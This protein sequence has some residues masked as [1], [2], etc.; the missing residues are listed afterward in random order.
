MDH[1]QLL[2]MIK[3]ALNASAQPALELGCNSTPANLA[4]TLRFVEQQLQPLKTRIAPPALPLPS[5]ECVA[6]FTEGRTTP[7]ETQHVVA[8]AIH[9][10]GILFQLISAVETQLPATVSEPLERSLH[11]RL[12]ALGPRRSVS[13][14]TVEPPAAIIRATAKQA[15]NHSPLQL[16][17][18]QPVTVAQPANRSSRKVWIVVLV[19]AASL[20]LLAGT[21]GVLGLLVWSSR[22]TDDGL[23]ASMPSNLTGTSKT[24]G[25]SNPSVP[26]ASHVPGSP[27]QPTLRDAP[28]L[29]TV[30]SPAEGTS[31][32]LPTAN[33]D[34][35][36]PLDKESTQDNVA[37]R[38]S[39]TNIDR[40][41]VA[42]AE[43]RAS[44]A[45][46]PPNAASP[47]PVVP[48][49]PL[50]PLVVWREVTGILASE[51]DEGYDNWQTVSVDY[52]GESPTEHV[53]SATDTL[54]ELTGGSALS[55]EGKRRITWLTLPT[56]YAKGDLAGGGQLVMGQDTSLKSNWQTAHSAALQVVFGSI[57][58]LDVPT[59]MELQ[60]A[61]DDQSS[62]AVAIEA[63]SSLRVQ[64]LGTAL[65]LALFSGRAR[66]GN[67][68]IQAG[69]K[70]LISDSLAAPV[71]T[72]PQ[73][74]DLTTIPEWAVRLP[75]KSAVP[76]NILANLDTT[77]ALSVALDK[78]LLSMAKNL[79]VNNHAGMNNFRNLCWW[80]ASLA[81]DDSRS[82]TEHAF[83]PVRVAAF[84]RLLF[85]PDRSRHQLAR[86]ELFQKLV[87]FHA[88]RSIASRAATA[89]SA[90]VDAAAARNLPNNPTVDANVKLR[91]WIEMARGAQANRSD[92][93]LWLRMLIE[94][95]PQIAAFA[96]YLLRKKF[97]N[98]PD[99]S[100]ADHIRNR[101]LAHKLWTKIVA[102]NFKP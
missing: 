64:K 100:P 18:H 82:A 44:S 84:D 8:A 40:T 98:G 26:S 90:T 59:K 34:P 53:P 54:P 24:P 97:S 91:A 76:R 51:T 71:P 67:Q 43:K 57:V 68:Q 17:D 62:T 73:S 41:P 35:S 45:D 61:G 58:L 5:A 9:D 56:C 50:G 13:T 94:D 12:L 10:V 81:V 25:P 2:Q 30:S 88:A 32:N 87:A 101:T 33:L 49:Q 27:T 95:D 42:A 7:A 60:L 79:N 47:V 75:E 77:V 74:D 31:A 20:F 16:H 37:V 69:D 36:T 63:T 28:E 96:D 55:D 86:R 85:D 80:R 89:T 83:W 22:T 11:E 99:F 19:A 23:Q 52:A 1:Q 21:I 39:P 93:G 15:V 72:Q 46:Q 38:P 65:E 70:L 66:I 29:A 14:E 3:R 6:A 48:P 92:F 4:S 78:Q 102:E